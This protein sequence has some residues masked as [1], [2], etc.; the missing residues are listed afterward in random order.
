MQSEKRHNRKCCPPAFYH[1]FLAQKRV[2]INKRCGTLS[3]ARRV[4]HSLL[5]CRAEPSQRSIRVAIWHGPRIGCVYIYIHRKG[6][7]LLASIHETRNFDFNVPIWILFFVQLLWIG[8]KI[9]KDSIRILYC[10]KFWNVTCNADNWFHL[11]IWFS[12]PVLLILIKCIS[13]LKLVNFIRKFLHIGRCLSV[14]FMKSNIIFERGIL[15]H[16]LRILRYHWPI[17]F[18]GIIWT[19]LHINGTVFLEQNARTTSENY[20][21]TTMT[22]ILRSYDDV[23]FVKS[24]R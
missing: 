16:C 2:S 17:L 18:Y 6:C 20:A 14:C 7:L 23:S 19:R 13:G 8:L 10:K 22:D 4:F 5:S 9:C 3:W 21:Y 1:T 24:N 11:I 12:Y 15:E